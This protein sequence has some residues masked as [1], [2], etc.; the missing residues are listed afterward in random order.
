MKRTWT[1]IGVSDVPSSFKWYPADLGQILDSD[2]TVLVCL[3]QW[4]EEPR[5]NPVGT[6]RCTSRRGNE[7]IE[8]RIETLQP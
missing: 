5:A 6:S 3:H 1:I 2:G 8:P 4:V 7:E